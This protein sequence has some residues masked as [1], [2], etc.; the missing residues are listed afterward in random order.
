MFTDQN[1]SKLHKLNSNIE[2]ENTLP[3]LD[4]SCHCADSIDYEIE[5]LETH[6]SDYD[7]EPSSAL[8]EP[9]K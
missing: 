9:K 8:A 6:D 5:I 7:D 3:R 2:S 4:E 1:E